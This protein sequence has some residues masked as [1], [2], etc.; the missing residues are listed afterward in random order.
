MLNA[1]QS[2]K[3]YFLERKCNAKLFYSLLS[4]NIEFLT[5]KKIRDVGLLAPHPRLPTLPRS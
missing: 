1:K 2:I 5:W 4:F 3:G